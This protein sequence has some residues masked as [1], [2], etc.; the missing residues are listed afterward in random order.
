MALELD[1][2]KKIL[3]MPS[4]SW[5]Y[6]IILSY[7]IRWGNWDSKTGNSLSESGKVEAVRPFSPAI[8]FPH[9]LATLEKHQETCIFLTAGFSTAKKLEISQMT[10]PGVTG[11]ELCQKSQNEILY[12]H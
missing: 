5:H 11:T 9:D 12:S 6:L 4:A 2:L 3:I 10:V 7:Y 8:P 1:K